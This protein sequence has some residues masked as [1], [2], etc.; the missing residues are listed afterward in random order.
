MTEVISPLTRIELAKFLPNERA[1]RA[2]ESLFRIS[3]LDENVIARI[4][5][6]LSLLESL[7]AA[8]L[9][10]NSTQTD[11]IDLPNNAPH[12]T[13]ERRIQWN[14][15][16]GTLDVGLYNG[17]VLQ[18]GQEV[19]YYAL[20]DSGVTIPDGASVMMTGTIGNSGKLK[21][22]KA[23]ADGSVHSKFML[24]I[25]T[26]EIP[27]GEFG[28]VTSF[29]LVRGIDTSAYTDGDRLYFDP[30]IPGGLTKTEPTAPKFRADI[31]IVV[32]AHSNGSIFV[33]M[34]N[35][36]TVE[37]LLNVSS[38]ATNNHVLHYVSANS[39]WESTDTLKG[40]KFGGSTDYSTFE[41]DGTLVAHGAATFWQDIDFP[42][43]VRTTGAG[44]PSLT[45]MQGN[46]TAP[47]WA[48]NDVNV[49]EGQEKI[50]AWKEG[51]TATF[52]I[53]VITN[54]LDASSRYL[55]FDVEWCWA[56]VDGVLSSAATITSP[57]LLI[58]ANTISKTHKVYNL[59]TITLTGGHVGAHVFARLKRVASVGTA[60]TNNPWCSMLQLHI[61]CDT[62]G[63]RTM[64]AK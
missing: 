62:I 28:Y 22:A 31:A 3:A 58:P 44:I 37:D 24:G 47:S 57:E 56:D 9:P 13:R 17:V 55:R 45:T 8:H 2:F 38:S 34:K 42:I 61:E 16:D 14:P 15:N 52:H 59:G 33:R 4:E 20:N 51:S 7:P 54:G 18:S 29:G 1:I 32:N 26:H 5:S 49:C 39:R 60:P 6:A 36:E 25:A 43:I 46:I 21:I 27:D 63:S 11:Y 50:H 53:H 40:L 35:G 12:V 30:A 48:V 23:V 10:H 19:H 64:T 41:D